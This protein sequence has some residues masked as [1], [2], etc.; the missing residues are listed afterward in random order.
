M[1]DPRAASLRNIVLF[2]AVTLGIGNLAGWHFQA[3]EG[4]G[5][6]VFILSPTLTALA[7]RAFAGD[8]WADAGFAPGLRRAPWAYGLALALYPLAIGLA[9]ALGAAAG[10]VG[11]FPGALAGLPGAVLAALPAFLLT[12]VLE[13]IGWRGYLDPRLAALG[14]AAPWRYLVV[15][16]VWQLWHLGYLHSHPELVH[17]PPGLF[18][19]LMFAATVAMATIYAELRRLTGSLWPAVLAHGL[20]NALAWPLIAPGTL[21]ITA[22]LLFAPR[23]EGLVVL[24]V[25]AL[26]A[27]TLAWPRRG[28][29]S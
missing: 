6:L 29:F 4:L 20:G 3:F 22:P 2:V 13:E 11:G 18:W 21:R 17:L 16:L 28:N 5:G 24:G 12:A 9:L 25:L 26:V 8:G 14:L 15:G 19:P 7:L 1:A 27:L 23:P 10:A